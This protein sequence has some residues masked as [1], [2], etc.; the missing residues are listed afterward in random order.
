M[1]GWGGDTLS[2]DHLPI[3]ISMTHAA[4]MG[5]SAPATR[6]QYES[7]D[8]GRFR[9]ELGSV[10]IDVDQPDLENVNSPDS[11]FA[12]GSGQG[13]HTHHQ[14]WHGTTGKQPLVKR[15]LRGGRPNQTKAVQ[16]L[17]QKPNG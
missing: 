4:D 1:G 14:R 13:C 12:S 7:A 15:R 9:A 5:S 16:N 17:L 10:D 8:W 6:F 2:S 3:T 11:L